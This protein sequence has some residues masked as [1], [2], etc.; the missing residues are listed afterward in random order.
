MYQKS[1]EI[2]PHLCKHMQVNMQSLSVRTA[3]RVR[4]VIDG[5][6]PALMGK[7]L[8]SFLCVLRTLLMISNGSRNGDLCSTA[9]L[10]HGCTMRRVTP[11][12]SHREKTVARSPLEIPGTNT[13]KVK[14]CA[15]FP[16]SFPHARGF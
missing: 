14:V 3:A 16:N 9:T 8:S 1:Y 7:L 5:W 10:A 15:F 12:A 13:F 2:F 11:F 4:P 6:V